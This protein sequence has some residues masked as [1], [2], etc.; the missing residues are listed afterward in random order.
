ME[1]KTSN[2]EAQARCQTIYGKTIP[3]AS[4]TTQTGKERAGPAVQNQ[5]LA[6]ADTRGGGCN[7]MGLSHVLCAKE[8]QS[9]HEDS[10]QFLKI[11]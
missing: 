2:S 6:E 4:P 7:R 10:G 9:E 5:D 8:G 11:E 3:S 1:G